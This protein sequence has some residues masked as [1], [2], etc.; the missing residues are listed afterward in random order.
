[1]SRE[2]DQMQIIGINK[3]ALKTI[4]RFVKNVEQF[5][6]NDRV[7]IPVT[8]YNY[9]DLGNKIKTIISL[10]GEIAYHK[11]KGPNN[12]EISHLCEIVSQ[13]IPHEEME[14]LDEL[15]FEKTPK[16]SEFVNLENL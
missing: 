4:N 8:F 7:S 15:L 11:D 5:G 12:I 13:I 14:F 2:L 9:K 16:E 3:D 10:I 1:M 6:E